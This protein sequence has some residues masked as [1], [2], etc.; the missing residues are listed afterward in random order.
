MR[1]EEKRNPVGLGGITGLPRRIDDDL[2]SS[3]RNYNTASSGAQA[4]GEA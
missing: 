1:A 2:P 3:A 4:G